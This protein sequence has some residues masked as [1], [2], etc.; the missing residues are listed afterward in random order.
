MADEKI[1]KAMEA[2]HGEHLYETLESYIV[3]AADAISG[4][5]PGARRD[6]V[7]NYIKR[8]QEFEAI[9]IRVENELKY[10]GEIK[11]MVIRESRT[12]EFAR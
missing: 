3:Q 5:R 7:E 2:H 4:A 11:I 10:P 9:A 12:I 1:I 6:S 8:L